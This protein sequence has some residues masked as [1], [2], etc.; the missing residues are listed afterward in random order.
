VERRNSAEVAQLGSLGTNRRFRLGR[1]RAIALVPERNFRTKTEEEG[2][3]IGD[4][5]AGLTIR[6]DFVTLKTDVGTVIRYRESAPTVLRGY[7][8]LRSEV[9]HRVKNDLQ[10]IIS[11]LRVQAE[12]LL[13]KLEKF[14]WTLPK[15]FAPSRQFTTYLLA[16]K[17]ILSI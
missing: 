3:R 4:L 14:C 5:T 16:Q 17:A 8:L 15:E 2:Q 1:A 13:P 10:S 6:R 7:S 11:L 9:H 12:M